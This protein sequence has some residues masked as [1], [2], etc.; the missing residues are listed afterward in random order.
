MSVSH[1]HISLSPV[2]D[3]WSANLNASFTSLERSEQF[4]QVRVLSKSNNSD[5]TVDFNDIFSTNNNNKRIIKPTMSDFY[6]THRPTFSP[7]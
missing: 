7:K 3:E 1:W 6:K 2:V 4:Y 5:K